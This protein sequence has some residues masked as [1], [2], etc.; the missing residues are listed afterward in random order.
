MNPALL[1]AVALGGALGALGRHGVNLLSER[2]LQAAH[3]GQPPLATFAVNLLGSFAMGLLAG[4]LLMRL[5]PND[6]MRAFAAT[7]LLGGFTTFSAFS[8]ELGMMLQQKQYAL[9]LGY[10]GVSVVAGL[11]AFLLGMAL[12]RG[13]A[14]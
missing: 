11:A 9:A 13:L 14:A 12:M 8:L 10:G 2:I 1:T 6:A 4:G 3:I 5:A 7:G